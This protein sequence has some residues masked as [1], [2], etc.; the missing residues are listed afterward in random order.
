MIARNDN[1]MFI[2]KF[3]HKLPKLL[4]L[5]DSGHFCEISSVNEDICLW[6]VFW[7][8]KLMFVMRIANS[9]DPYHPIFSF[10]LR[11]NTQTLYFL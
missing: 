6:Q 3:L 11:Q 4:K 8:Y 5:F 9:N 10:H 1:F 7:F 2:G